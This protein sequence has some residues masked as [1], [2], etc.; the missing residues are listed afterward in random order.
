MP[1]FMREWAAGSH[2]YRFGD[3]KVGEVGAPLGLWTPIMS[4]PIVFHGDDVGA[5]ET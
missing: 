3:M 4:A 1:R 5:S 2:V